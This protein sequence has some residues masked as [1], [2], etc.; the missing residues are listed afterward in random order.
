MNGF[1]RA[2]GVGG[3]TNLYIPYGTAM[4]APVKPAKK[5]GLYFV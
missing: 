4:H 1:V 5:T 2:H 3:R